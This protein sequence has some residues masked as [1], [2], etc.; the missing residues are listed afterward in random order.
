MTTNKGGRNYAME[1]KK[2]K[3]A[4]LQAITMIDAATDWIE[5]HSV[6]EARAY[7]VANELQLAWLTRYALPS[8]ITVDRGK[9]L[10]VELKAVMAND[11]RIPCNSF[12]TRSPQANAILERHTNLLVFR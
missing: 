2:D 3:D 6:P 1:G 5:I 11:Y 10:L 12:S 9:E 4:Y 7:S 8:K